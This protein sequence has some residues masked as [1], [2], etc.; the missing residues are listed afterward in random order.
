MQ[1]GNYKHVETEFEYKKNVKTVNRQLWKISMDKKKE[2]EEGKGKIKL[3]ESRH[4]MN[5]H[6]LPII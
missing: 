3:T 1:H 6:H 4:S 2:K 5:I